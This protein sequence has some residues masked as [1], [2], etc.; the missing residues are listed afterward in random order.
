MNANQNHDDFRQLWER[1]KQT[2]QNENDMNVPDDTTVLKM[3]E[4]ARQVSPARD[5]NIVPISLGRRGRW[6]P[7]A[8]AASVL[9][10]V[11]V[12]GLTYQSE[13]PNQ[14]QL[15]KAQKININGQN[16]RFLCNNGCSAQDIL[17]SANDIIKK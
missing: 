12:I 1:R 6:I 15:L 17:V 14:P 11:G 9:I 8:A 3:A 10:G 4:L 7:Y 2:W 5:E 13:M 16:V